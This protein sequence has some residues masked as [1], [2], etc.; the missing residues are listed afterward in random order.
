MQIV[1]FT[2]L[3]GLLFGLA[4]A[5]S[6][7]RARDGADLQRAGR[8]GETLGRRRLARLLVAGEIALALVLLASAGLLS[9]SLQQLTARDLGFP[10]KDLL[11][12][13]LDLRTSRYAEE[14][15]RVAF[16]RHL[17]ERLASLPGVA[18]ATLWGPSMLG[19][20]TWVVEACAEGLPDDDPKNIIMSWRHS[21]NP[22]ALAN[23]GIRL[24]SGRDVSWDD[25]ASKPRVAVV[26]ESTARAIGRARIRSA[27]ASGTFGGRV[28]HRDRR[29]GRRPTPRDWIWPTRPS[30]SLRRVSDRSATS[31]SPTH[32]FPTARWPWR[33]ASRAAAR[34]SLRRCERRSGNSTRR[35]PFTR[36]PGSTICSTNRIAAAA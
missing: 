8:Q 18:S 9:K 22:G 15:S 30:A 25:D 7:A 14:S 19:R 16:A 26:S 13:R 20:A 6:G 31:T 34:R 17:E 12:L 33:C 35:C 5:L 24:L 29:R 4:P 3:A 27:S 28:G 2:L 23:L 32:S 21:V 1:A 10:T 11:T 36:S